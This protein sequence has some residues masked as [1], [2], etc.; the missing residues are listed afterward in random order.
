LT[1]KVNKLNLKV[2][3]EF[4]EPRYTYRCFSKQANAS[5]EF[6]GTGCK[7]KTMSKQ[8]KKCSFFY[9]LNDNNAVKDKTGE[10][11]AKPPTAADNG[12][13]GIWPLVNGADWC[14]EFVVKAA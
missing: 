12:T 7:E 1:K 6:L 10:C 13:L 9:E 4:A 11:R 14:G 2:F 5:Q 3:L 8:C